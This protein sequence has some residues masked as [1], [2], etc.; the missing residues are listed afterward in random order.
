MNTQSDWAEKA[1]GD[2][3][4]AYQMVLFLANR[5]MSSGELMRVMRKDIQFYELQGS[6]SLKTTI[7][8]VQVNPPTK[9]GAREAKVMRGEFAKRI[10]DK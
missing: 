10:W 3:F 5:E 7:A 8:L 9:S 2:A 1:V 4:V 6:N